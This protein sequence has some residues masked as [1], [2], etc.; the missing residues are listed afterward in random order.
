MAREVMALRLGLEVSIMN[1]IDE[2]KR[3]AT[4]RELIG[5]GHPFLR[6]AKM[7]GVSTAVL[8]L[9]VMGGKK[10]ADAPSESDF[11][12]LLEKVQN[13]EAD[14]ERLKDERDKLEERL[15][16]QN[17]VKA[18]AAQRPLIESQLRNRGMP[19]EKAKYW[20]RIVYEVNKSPRTLGDKYKLTAG[21]VSKIE[22]LLQK[23]KLIWPGHFNKI[24]T[25]Y[26]D[27]R[28]FNLKSKEAI[29]SRRK[30]VQLNYSFLVGPIY[31]SWQLNNP[32]YAIIDEMHKNP[33]KYGALMI[34]FGRLT[35]S[36]Y[37]LIDNK[38]RYPDYKPAISEKL[39]E[40]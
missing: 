17:E 28:D 36:D 34:K 26:R 38:F 37:D 18:A 1:R 30:T 5:K 32:G 31:D 20:S 40:P 6:R 21:D 8:G 35:E 7:L 24:A 27:T 22:E 10:L 4:G 3:Q 12:V 16:W 2:L 39:I 19:P 23:H 14:S 33:K 13:L 9:L 29:A 25:A 15:Y 11:N